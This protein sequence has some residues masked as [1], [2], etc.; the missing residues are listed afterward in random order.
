MDFRLSDEHV[1]IRD[2]VRRFAE[3]EVWPR[4]EEL[5][6]TGEMPYDLIKKCSELGIQGM[7]MPEEFGGSNLGVLA[8]VTALEELAR[9]D[10]SLATTIFVAFGN[11]NLIDRFGTPEMKKEWL[12]AFVR[13]E[14]IGSF[15]LTEPG[16]GSDNRT[17]RTTVEVK[18]DHLVLNGVKAFITNAGTRIS[19][20]V[21]VAAAVKSDV[22]DPRD[23][24]FCFVAVPYGTAGYTQ[25]EKYRKLGWRSSDTRELYFDNVVVPRENMITPPAKGGKGLDPGWQMLSLGRVSLAATSL[26]IS[27]ACLHHSLD[28]SKQRM[29]FGRPIG[30]YQRVQDLIVEQLVGLETSRLLTQ[31]A[32]WQIDNGINDPQLVSIAKLYATEAAKKATDLAI[33]VHGGMGFMDECPVSRYYRDVRVH[34]IGD[35]TSEIQRMIIARTL[36][37]RG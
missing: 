3:A 29:Q 35:G 31:K 15:G 32:A 26:G 7:L 2:T 28:Y 25:S 4:A 22:E 27:S 19:T 36:G 34:T 10:A 13:G 21:V 17:L 23:R 20:N 30:S 33:Q 12:A 1:A 8:W 11:A 18:D 24:E 14:G 16:G 9:G 37:L 5:D 6:R